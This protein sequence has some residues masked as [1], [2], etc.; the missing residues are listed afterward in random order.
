MKKLLLIFLSAIIFSCTTEVKEELNAVNNEA[1]FNKNVQTFMD[2]TTAFGDEDIDGVMNLFADSALWSPPEYNSYEWLNKDELKVALT[3][4]MNAF[5]NLKFTPGINL[6][7]GNL[8]DGFWGGSRY[9]SDGNE[10]T[11][12]LSSS[13][14]NNIRVYGTWSSTHTESGKETF[15][16]WYAIVNF[17]DSGKI[18]RFNDWFNVDGLQVQI[19]Q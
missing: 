11:S 6:P 10:N 12:S 7:G 4:Y 1:A 5:D 2:F 15:S 17:N 13:N 18:V 14:P 8:V 9:R 16:K 19:N 3:N